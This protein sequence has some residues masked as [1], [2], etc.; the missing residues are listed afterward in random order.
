MTNDLR[1]IQQ[2]NEYGK[3]R[4][5]FLFIFD[6]LLQKPLLIKANE[7]NPQEILFQCNQINNFNQNPQS[8]DNQAFNKETHFSKTPP[9]F[10]DYQKAFSIV[11]KN[12]EWG[13]TYLLNLSA[14]TLVNTNLTLQEIFFRSVAKYKLWVRNEFVCFSPETFV[15]I[16]Q[17]K[18]AT[19][20]MKGTIDATIPNAAQIILADPKESAE[21]HTIV[22]LLRN[23]L[24][25]I[26]K[27]VRVERFRYVESVPTQNK[28]L[29]QVSSKIVGDLSND[30]PAHLGDLLLAMLP[31]GSVS[32]APKRKTVEIILA[33]EQ[34]FK[35]AGKPYERDYYTGIFGYFDG[36][37]LDAGVMIRFI[38]QVDNQLVFK[39]GGGITFM[40]QAPAEYQE[41]IDKV[42]LPI[43]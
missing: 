5:P 4:I 19:Y 12:L 32:G 18:I 41:L 34:G 3:N 29:L 43:Y 24:S 15:Q 11:Q 6:F 42:Y 26:S 7:I 2:I 38:Q 39:S 21:H 40:S 14:P 9:D 22:D 23:D 35:I 25:Q 10:V 13:N 33:A 28:T 8:I 37:N 16:E 30:Y 1:I 27:N 36:E 31:A 20:P 17:Q